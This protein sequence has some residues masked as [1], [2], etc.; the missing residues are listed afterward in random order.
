M[1]VALICNMNN[2]FFSLARYLRDLGIETDLLLL[3][4]EHPHFHPSHDTFDLSY[5]EYTRQLDW[6]D[7]PSFSTVSPGKIREQLEGYDFTVAC[8]TVPAFMHKAGLPMDL[9]VPYGSDF[10]QDPF[11]PFFTNP[12]RKLKHHYKYHAFHQA[13]KKGIQAVPLINVDYLHDFSKKT[14]KRMGVSERIYLFSLPMVY[15]GVFAPGKI[16]AYYD[17]SAWYHEFKK[18]RE[19]FDLVVFN[20]S[21]HIWKNYLDPYSN[22]GNDRVIRGIHR[23]KK[24]APGVRIGLVTFEY[25]P[26][27][28][29]ARDLI[30]ELDMEENVRW[31]PL[32]SRKEIMVGLSLSD[33]VTGQF[34]HGV[35]SCGTILEALACGKP[36]LHNIDKNFVGIPDLSDYPY[37]QTETDTDIYEALKGYLEDPEKYREVG[38]QGAKW[39]QRAYAENCVDKYVQLFQAKAAGN[40]PGIVA[41]WPPQHSN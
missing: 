17:R 9:F 30:R 22:K 12:L 21:R 19:Q 25:G 16:E 39:Y 11:G 2:I 20:H 10:Y 40:Y 41:Q 13:Q 6:G 29:A 23:L 37:F 4:N 18:V 38:K 35:T 32:M 15:A 27:V 8:G 26:D 36:L 31:F 7:E 3:N 24:E 28:Q 33:I 34:F 14:I 5:Q 1:K